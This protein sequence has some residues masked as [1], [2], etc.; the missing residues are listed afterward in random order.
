MIPFRLIPA[1]CLA[2]CWLGS[3]CRQSLGQEFPPIRNSEQN[4]EA[5]PMPAAVA[6]KSMRLPKD[7]QVSVFAS[8]PNVQNPIAMTFDPRGRL[9]I[10]ENYTYAERT[11]RFDLS[12]RDRV[13]WFEDT[14]QDGIVDRREVFL[15]NVQMLTSVEVGQGGV[16]LM[17]PPLLLFVPDANEDGKPDG[18]AQVVLDGFEVARDNYHNFA[19]GLKWG[20]DGWLYGRCGHSCPGLVGVPNTKVEERI[21]LDGGIWRFHPKRK[22]FEALC[23]GTT[24]P[25]GHDWDQNG[26]LFFINTVIGHLWHMMPGTHLKES[27]GESQNPHVYERLDMIA[28]HYHFDTKGSWTDS[29]DGKANELGGG[30]AHIGAAICLSRD[31][32]EQYR[33]KLMT[34]NMHGKRINVERLERHDSGYIG[35]H[36]PDFLIAEDPFFRGIDLQ[37]GPD[38]CLYFIDWS[39]T[40]EC[41][42]HTGVH[43]TS[44]RI[45]RVSYTGSNSSS[46]RSEFAKP[47]CMAGEGELPRLWKDFQAGR[48]SQSDLL[49]KLDHENE[50]VR[51]WAI[52]LLTDEWPLDTILG[53]KANVIYPTNERVMNAFVDHVSKEESSLVHNT[54]ASVMQ[55]VALPDR[56]RLAK[57]LLAIERYSND[58][59]LSHLIWYG[60]IPVGLNS[61][62]QLLEATRDTRWPRIVRWV[63]RFL[64]SESE[65]KP[66]GLNSWL[67][68]RNK[69]SFGQKYET[70]LGLS[71]AFRG[72]RQAPKP[73]AWKEWILSL[74]SNETAERQTAPD[75]R[76]LLREIETIFGDG[77]AVQEILA[78]ALDT[79]IEIKTRQKA[80][81]TWIDSRP[82]ELRKVCEGLLDTR[83][84]NTT[85]MQGLA[86]INDQEIG[87]LLSKKFKRFQPEDRNAVISVLVSRPSFVIA[88]LD[89][90]E[91]VNGPI[92]VSDITPFHVRQ[93][94]SLNDVS[95]SER[96]RKLWGEIKES[97][98]EKRNE[99]AYWKERLAKEDM[100]DANVSRGRV[101]FD[102]SCSQ[103]HAM[104]GVGAKIGPELTGAQRTSFEYW[105]EN[106]LDPSAVVGKDYRMTVIQ[107]QD[108][109]TVSGLM[110]SNDGKTISI[111]TPSGLERIPTEEA[112]QIK[113]SELSPMPEGLLKAMDADQV[114]DLLGYLMHPTQV[115]YEQ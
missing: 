52:R 70:L 22:V 8:E 48:L 31:W 110:V 14:D 17:C 24:N 64:A 1:I 103:C 28:D 104:Y 39:D 91:Q 78:I 76:S 96:I 108:G 46:Q 60:L 59:N 18:P 67:M 92:A 95:A 94:H 86:R 73:P 83:I 21:P 20:P 99:I 81:S 35:R 69:D 57:K 23:H 75:V 54:L 111:Q 77:R 3:N 16:Y 15:D 109:R 85:A 107:T 112:E 51:A 71:D 43:R 87:V 68:A 55:R 106:I 44:G 50:F 7:F 34:L 41:H 97:S 47:A 84:L 79:K 32:P 74:A 62:E 100:K 80:L 53:P 25:W 105:L 82:S 29:R 19:N 101:L 11:Q 89:S 98:E 27:F 58:T 88:L 45:Y 65:R 6:A 42:D 63:S 66:D 56:V 36:E 33:N 5:Q 26:E 72:W 102:K 113:K 61:S 9:W 4:Q 93:I 10:A 2:L 90:L 12:M 115:P 40:G 49:S 38:G 30:H 13:L 114:R 37:W